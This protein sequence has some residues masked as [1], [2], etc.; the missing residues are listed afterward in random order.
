MARQIRDVV[1][2]YVKLVGSGTSEDVVALYAPDATV[3]DPIGTPPKHGH[4]AIR[5]FYNVLANLEREST[6]HA[7][8][9]RIG[10]NQAAFMFTLVTKAGDQRVTLR[11][12]DVM[13]FDDEGRITHMRAYWSQD[14]MSIEPA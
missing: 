9:V 10:G 7:D 5:E 4:D 11:P 3:E 14:D 12:I 13:E 8:T 1:E 6:L 2:E